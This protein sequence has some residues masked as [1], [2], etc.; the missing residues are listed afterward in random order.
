MHVLQKQWLVTAWLRNANS[1]YC[2]TF[3]QEQDCKNILKTSNIKRVWDPL[4]KLYVISLKNNK[5][6]IIT[7]LYIIEIIVHALFWLFMV[8]SIDTNDTIPILSQRVRRVAMHKLELWILGYWC[9]LYRCLWHYPL[10]LTE[11]SMSHNA[12]TRTWPIMIAM[13]KFNYNVC[14]ISEILRRFNLSFL[15]V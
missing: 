13:M 5:Q 1:I 6:L 12:W 8:F 9:I 10:R 11:S 15:G 2:W 7:L 14:G 4:E 3:S